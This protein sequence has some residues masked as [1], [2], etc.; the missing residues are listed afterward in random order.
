MPG[1]KP[2]ELVTAETVQSWLEIVRTDDVTAAAE[3]LGAQK[4]TGSNTAPPWLLHASA[5]EGAERIVELLIQRGA[6]VDGRDRESHRMTPIMA[7]AKGRTT[8]HLGCV[9]R[10]LESG[11]DPNLRDSTGCSALGRAL[12][13]VDN[14]SDPDILALTE[15]IVAALLEHGADAASSGAAPAVFVALSL[16][17]PAILKRLLDAGASVHGIPQVRK[18]SAGHARAMGARDEDVQGLVRGEKLVPPLEVAVHAK[19]PA[20]VSL[21]LERG[22]SP[23]PAFHWDKHT[24]LLAAVESNQIEILRLLIAHGANINAPQAP[25]QWAPLLWG[26]FKGAGPETV[27]L[28]IDAGANL[29]FI[30]D[31]WTALGMAWAGRRHD[32]VELLLSRGARA[33][34]MLGVLLPDPA[35]VQME[36]ERIGIPHGMPVVDVKVGTAA[37]AAGVQ[38]DDVFVELKGHR[39]E[40]GTDFFTV[41][42]TLLAGDVIG[43]VLV[44]AGTPVP[45]EFKV[46]PPITAALKFGRYPQ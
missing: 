41:T 13:L 46:G 14:E 6:K 17:S 21:L 26:C 30:A 16:E 2:E 44:R 18:T 33:R 29:D 12:D 38:P 36:L 25:N 32:L 5:R 23:D 15:E 34:G 9:K 24:P 11:A 7:A 37:D 8:G 40:T 43:A 35:K 3:W 31:G 4:M 20:S 1:R 10:L 42:A 45:V 27:T 28:L 19:R 39:I 22:A